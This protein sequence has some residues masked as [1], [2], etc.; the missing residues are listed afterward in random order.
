M[1]Y[2]KNVLWE[3]VEERLLRLPFLRK[4]TDV[5]VPIIEERVLSFLHKGFDVHIQDILR[6]KVGPK[7]EYVVYES[8]RPATFWFLVDLSSAR[9]GDLFIIRLYIRLSNGEFL[10]HDEHE[11]DGA[12]ALPIVTLSSSFAPTCRF[13]ITQARGSSREVRH[14]V[15]GKYEGK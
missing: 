10:L 2:F 13:T 4:F 7:E 15:F 3:I 9:D 6:P 14:E 5:L 12:L 11:L 8:T 1:E